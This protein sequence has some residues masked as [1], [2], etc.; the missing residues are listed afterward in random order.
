[1]AFKVGDKVFVLHGQN[2]Y[3]GKIIEIKNHLMW[4]FEV[5]IE[6][7]FQIK[8]ANYGSSTILT[9]DSELIHWPLSKLEEVIYG[10]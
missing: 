10:I 8:G 3:M 1:M 2:R 5:L 6:R 7:D 9:I 4:P